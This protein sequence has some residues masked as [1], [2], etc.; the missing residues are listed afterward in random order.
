MKVLLKS[1]SWR[2]SLFDPWDSREYKKLYGELEGKYIGES[3]NEM[4]DILEEELKG[5]Y[6]GCVSDF[7]EESDITLATK[8]AL[9]CVHHKCT[10][11]SYALDCAYEGYKKKM[12][13]LWK[14]CYKRAVKELK[15]LPMGIDP[16]KDPRTV[17]R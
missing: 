1:Q 4:L 17:E 5:K 2:R 13:V 6:M 8:Y 7:T 12:A 9:L 3:I 11:L 15:H 10:H 16:I 14:D